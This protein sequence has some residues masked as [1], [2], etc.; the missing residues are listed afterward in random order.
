MVRV[1]CEIQKPK[2]LAGQMAHILQEDSVRKKTDL[3]KPQAMRGHSRALGLFQV[4]AW[5]SSFEDSWA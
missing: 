1:K 2:L 3:S 5:A 4:D